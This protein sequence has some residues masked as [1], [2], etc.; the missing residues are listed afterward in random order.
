[1][2]F[3]SYRFFI[4]FPLV[5]LLYFLLPA[6]IRW[7]WL[8]ACSVYFY[9]CWRAKYILLLG[10]SVAVTWLGSL[11]IDALHGGGVTRRAGAP[12]PAGCC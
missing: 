2:L 3:N 7:L 12:L 9:M 10:F 8:L 5:A 1:M 4:F 6:K 11:V